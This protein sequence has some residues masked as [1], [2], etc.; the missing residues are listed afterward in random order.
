MF[1]DVTMVTQ[2][3]HATVVP[4]EAV[5]QSDTGASV[6]VVNQNNVAQ[7]RPVVLGASDAAGIAIKSGIQPGE[8]VVVMSAAPVRDGQTVRIGG[9]RPGGRHPGGAGGLSGA[10]GHHGPQSAAANLSSHRPRT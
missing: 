9:G 2:R 10:P 5:E 1:A 4:R 7:R 6:I 3:I 8:R